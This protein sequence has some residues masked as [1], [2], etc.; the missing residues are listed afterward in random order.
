MIEHKK[1]F[2]GG[3]GLLI[4]FAVTLGII[5]SPI[6]KGQNGLQYLDNL[7][8]SM[9]KGSAYYIQ[10]VKTET[11]PFSGK[12]V[13][14][15]IEMADEARAQQTA[16]LFMKGGALVNVSGTGLKVEGDLSKILANCLA[17]ADSMY[18]N[19]G[20]TISSKYGYNERQVLFNWWK[21]LKSMDKDLKKQK[22][23]EAAKVVSQVVKKAVECSYNY[24]Q[25]EPQKISDRPGIVI[26]SLVFYVVYTLWYGFAVMFMFEGWGLRLEH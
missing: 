18:I 15:V 16:S 3:F 22:E 20:R 17:D 12:S 2:Y 25:I 24:Y 5:F 19:D 13:Q 26:F 1:E 8:N 21:A 14:V 6:F 23:F 11:E 7:Y 10:T 9:S 4:G